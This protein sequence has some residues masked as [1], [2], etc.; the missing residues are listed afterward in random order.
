MLQAACC[1][2]LSRWHVN[3]EVTGLEPGFISKGS[4][5]GGGGGATGLK[6]QETQPPP[7]GIQPL[8]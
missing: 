8:W 5:L 3:T 4:G 1:D 6:C 2:L 7:L